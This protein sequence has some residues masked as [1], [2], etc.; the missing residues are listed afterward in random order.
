MSTQP[1]PEGFA[2]VAN[3]LMLQAELGIVMRQRN[4]LRSALQELLDACP[5][6][7]ED[8]ALNEAQ[9]KAEA[10]LKEVP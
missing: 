9:R 5:T 4:A 2:E 6:S 10:L 8:R 1:K 7:C 3:V